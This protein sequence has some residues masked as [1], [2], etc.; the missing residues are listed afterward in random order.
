MSNNRSVT[1]VAWECARRT[2]YTWQRSG[3]AARL[4][5][6]RAQHWATGLCNVDSLAVALSCVACLKCQ[7][8]H[9]EELGAPGGLGESL[10]VYPCIAGAQLAFT[11]TPGS[12]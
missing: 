4:L 1:S 7:F 8:R 12:V 10:L 3:Q 5:L 6:A 9:M 11:W 2:W